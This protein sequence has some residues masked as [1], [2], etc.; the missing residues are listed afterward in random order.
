MTD[1]QKLERLYGLLD[2]ANELASQFSGGYSNNFSSAEEFHSALDE[3]INKLK[4]G[5][6]DQID[7]LYI[8]FAPTCD[9]DDFIH[10]EGES[11][12]NEISELLSDLKKT[13][14]LCSLVEVI[15][16]YQNAVEKVMSGFKQKFNRTDLLTAYRS[17]KVFAQKGDLNEYGIKRYAFHGIG[18]HATFN[19]NSTVDFDFAFLP[20]QR[21]NGFDLWRLSEFVGSQPDKY[22]KYLDKNKLENDFN[23]LIQ[24]GTILNPK[25]EHSTDLY[26]FKAHLTSYEE[27]DLKLKKEWWKV[28]K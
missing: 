8:W 5:D 15:V 17:D 1:N 23:E 20:D 19:N 10:K 24:R 26:F 22:K 7:K 12:A 16:D 3:S 2:Q 25:M 13:L 9:W 11:L 21:H 4:A 27:A 6:Y 18:L 14:K 28:W